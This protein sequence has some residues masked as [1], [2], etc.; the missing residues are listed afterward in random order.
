MVTPRL[1]RILKS[2]YPDYPLLERLKAAPF[3]TA[4][5]EHEFIQFRRLQSL[6]Y[7]IRPAGYDVEAMQTEAFLGAVLAAQVNCKVAVTRC[8]YDV[9]VDDA[10][11]QR[12]APRLSRNM[13]MWFTTNA[14]LAHDRI[15]ALPIGITD[16]CG[17]SPYHAVIGDTQ[18]LDELIH[19]HPRADTTLVLM[20]FNDRTHAGRADVRALFAGKPFVT[21]ASYTADEGGYAGY[22]QG[23]RGHTF[24]LAPRGHGI[25]TPRMWEALYAGCI[26]IVQRV[27]AMRDFADLPIYFVDDWA[28][29][30]DEATL[31]KVR[32]DFR[33]RT[34]DLRKL[35]LSY[36][37]DEVCAALKA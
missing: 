23:L 27:Q 25:D 13:V 33:A 28:Q 12:V 37:F 14:N 26:P 30:A 17:F 8:E 11:Y 36:W 1:E 34:W 15:K 6:V 22:V 10:M 35:T 18:K 2:S 32:D 24:C 7:A 9:E 3:G 16:Y 21:T 31:F 5:P 29:A 4:I 19:T 20:N